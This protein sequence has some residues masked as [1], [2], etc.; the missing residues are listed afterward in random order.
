MLVVPGRCVRYRR[1]RRFFLVL[2]L[3]NVAAAV[4]I[5]SV[6]PG[7]SP[8]L[9]LLV[10][11]PTCMYRLQVENPRT[12]SPYGGTPRCLSANHVS[13][14]DWLLIAAASPRPVRFVMD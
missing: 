12:R 7:V 9:R 6:V 8:P 1:T 13:F 2:A 14:I 10:H 5:Y 4:Y 3:L 11:W